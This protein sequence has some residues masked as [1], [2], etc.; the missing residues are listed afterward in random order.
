MAF[1]GAAAVLLAAKFCR[2]SPLLGWREE[3][4][5]A[6]GRRAQDKFCF[7]VDL[8]NLRAE[9]GAQLLLALFPATLSFLDFGRESLPYKLKALLVTLRVGIGPYVTI[10]IGY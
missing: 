5:P 10:V 7:R 4:L 3:A 1:D 8:L 6:L 9:G 2:A